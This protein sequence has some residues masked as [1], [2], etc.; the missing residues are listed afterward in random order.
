MNKK[1]LT[2]VLVPLMLMLVASF[3]YAAWTDSIAIYTTATTGDVEFRILAFGVCSKSGELAISASGVGDYPHESIT[4]TISNTYPGC[5]A[6]FCLRVK[7]TGT[8][9]VKLYRLRIAYKDGNAGWMDYYYFAIPEGNTWCN[10]GPRVWFNNSLT[11]WST[12]RYYTA[13]GDLATIPVPPIAPEAEYVLGGY[14]KLADDAPQ[15]ENSGISV[16]LELEV[17]QA[18]P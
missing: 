4:V 18:V 1:L 5:W 10:I 13:G 17:I 14:F 12:W 8:I 15:W 11:W 3:G 6:Y 16:S 9:S 2:A 7:N